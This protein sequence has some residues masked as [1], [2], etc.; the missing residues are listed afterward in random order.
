MP[1]YYEVLGILPGCTDAEIKQA[2]RLALLKLHPDKQQL[3]TADSVVIEDK[4]SQLQLVKKAWQV[5][6]PCLTVRLPLGDSLSGMSRRCWRQS[7]LLQLRVSSMG[8]LTSVNLRSCVTFP[9]LLRDHPARSG[10]SLADLSSTW[11][12]DT[13]RHLDNALKKVAGSPGGTPNRLPSVHS[14]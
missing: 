14:F 3:P 11:L 7:R 12:K 4:N 2:Y 13:Y 1:T 8:R 9:S 5:R 10:S 6:I